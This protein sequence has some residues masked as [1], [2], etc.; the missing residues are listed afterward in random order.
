MPHSHHSHSGQFCAHARGTLEQ[1]VQAAVR[2]G[3]ATYGLSEHAPRGSPDDL[4]PEERDAGL[5]PA[6]LAVRFDAYVA[7]AHRLR[8]AY[9]GQIELLVGLET[10]NI[11]PEDLAQLEGVLAKY[12]TQIEYVVGSVHHVRGTPIDFDRSTYG[13]ALAAFGTGPTAASDFLSAYFDAQYELL[14]RIRPEVV[15]HIDLCR[16]YEPGLR[17]EDHPEAWAKLERNVRYAIEYGALFELNAAALRKGWPGPYPGKDVI[18][19]S[20]DAVSV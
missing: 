10:E 19:V 16:L 15:G 9:A 12:G 8:E 4:Y 14:L 1:V 13:R 11:S 3:F 7:E 5:T 18:D 6:D 2:R 17:L 20:G